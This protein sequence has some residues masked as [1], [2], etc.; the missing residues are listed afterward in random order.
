MMVRYRSVMMTSA[1]TSAPRV[2]R[3]PQP[4]SHSLL[5]IATD[6]GCSLPTFRERY[7]CEPLEITPLHWELSFD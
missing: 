5:S 1:L 6:S 7:C 4:E 3:L 2:A